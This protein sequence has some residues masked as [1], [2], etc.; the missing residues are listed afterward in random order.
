MS[1]LEAAFVV[2]ACAISACQELATSTNAIPMRLTQNGP[3]GQ[4]ERAF[5]GDAELRFIVP[6]S[7]CWVPDGRVAAA[8][9]ILAAKAANNVLEECVANAQCQDRESTVQTEKRLRIE[10]GDHRGLASRPASSKSAF[11]HPL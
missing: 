4:E 7:C 2:S 11:A 3:G 5:C 6:G 10:V 1:A 8:F 9:I